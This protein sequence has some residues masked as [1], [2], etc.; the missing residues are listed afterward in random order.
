MDNYGEPVFNKNNNLIGY[1]LNESDY[2]SIK[3]YYNNDN[4]LCN[5]VSIQEFDKNNLSFKKNIYLS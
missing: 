1:K 5:E 2:V 4:L 3:T